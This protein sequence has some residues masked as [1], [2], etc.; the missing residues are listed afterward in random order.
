MSLHRTPG[1]GRYAQVEREQ[2]WVLS[3]LPEGLT[4]PASI[5]D[6]YLTG[7]R[8]RLR[9]I[10]AGGAVTYKLGQKVRP[11]P[12]SPSIVR[13]TN[14]YLSPDEFEAL[15]TLA[16]RELRKTRWRSPY[17]GGRLVVDEFIDS[18]A[19]LVLAELELRPGQSPVELEVPAADVSEDDR[20][21]GGHLA[22]ISVADAPLLLRD[23]AALLR[24]RS[25]QR[26]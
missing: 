6:R 9:S 22:G 14:I 3:R 1:E 20:F 18:L 24:T 23:T 15:R 16:G 7:T 25:G 8:L 10:T 12:S 5:V 26:D 17:A 19:G 4:D 11:E 13:L 21:S 2:R